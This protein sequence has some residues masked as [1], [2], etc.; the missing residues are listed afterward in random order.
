[1]KLL[2][3]KTNSRNKKVIIE[4]STPTPDPSNTKH[5]S[6]EKVHNVDQSQLKDNTIYPS[7]KT[8]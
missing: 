1:M 7:I 6:P 3:L 5:S 2:T 8:S 4:M